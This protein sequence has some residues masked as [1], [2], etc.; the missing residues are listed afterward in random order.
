MLFKLLRR[1]ALEIQ[2][3]KSTREGP[4]D[5]TFTSNKS[6]SIGT[7][8]FLARLQSSHYLSIKPPSFNACFNFFEGQF[9]S[10][11]PL[12]R[13]LRL[14]GM[15]FTTVSRPWTVWTL[16]M[17]QF[18][19]KFLI[20][21]SRGLTRRFWRPTGLN[22]HTV[23]SSDRNEERLNSKIKGKRLSRRSKKLRKLCF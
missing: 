18:S 17:R 19:K 12:F 23:E 9:S 14:G 5:F 22:L 2:R 20:C 16:I 3:H 10:Q 15:T 11:Y 8:F 6:K 7:I 21:F 4:V 13:S 1:T